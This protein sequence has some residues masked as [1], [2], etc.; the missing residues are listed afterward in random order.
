MRSNSPPCDALSHAK[1]GYWSALAY[2]ALLVALNI[3]FAIMAL[4][5]PAAEWEGMEVYARA[6]RIIAFV[7]QAIGLVSIPALIMMLAS[8]YLS[9]TGFRRL[10]GLAG[11]AFG[12]AH[13]VLL[14]ASTSSR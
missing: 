10:W 14:E 3:S 11:L 2:A 6:H 8:I 13:A 7:P 9:A 4:Q 12:T 5:I 1:L